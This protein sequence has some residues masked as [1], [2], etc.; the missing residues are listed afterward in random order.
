MAVVFPLLLVD[1]DPTI[2]DIFRRA[3]G[4][5]FPEA[6]LKVVDSFSEA[7]AYLEG[8][9]G[10]GPRLVLLDIDLR[11]ELSGID[12]LTLLREHPQ[13]RLLP[14]VILS[15][16]EDQTIKEEAYDRGASAFTVKP[17]SYQAWKSYAEQLRAYWYG[18]ATTPKLWFERE[19]NE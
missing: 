5:A 1:D 18:T 6:D 4:N 17:F 16:G 8:L 11:S 15:A 3:I 14:V 10:R 2:A 13:G 9:F 19:K 12:F 7:A